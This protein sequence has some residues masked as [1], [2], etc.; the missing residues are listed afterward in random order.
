MRNFFNH[1]V[2][3]LLFVSPVLCA[4]QT[5]SSRGASDGFKESV[6]ASVIPESRLASQLEFLSDSLCAGR[7][8]GT[9][10]SAEAAFW[11]ERQYRMMRLLPLGSDYSHSFRA[12][13]I[14]GHNILGMIPSTVPSDRYIV[15]MAHYDNLG[16]LEGHF[17]PGADSNASGVVAMLSVAHIQASLSA[18]G[19]HYDANVIYVALDAKQRSMAGASALYDE[20]AKGS[21]RNPSTGALITTQ[22]VELVVNLDILGSSLAPLT[23]GREDFLMMLGGSEDARRKLTEANTSSKTFLQLSNQYYGSSDFTDLFLNRVSDQRIFIEHKVNSVMFTS[24]ITMSTN[25]I[26]DNVAS[27]NIPVFRKR[28][29]LIYNWLEKVAK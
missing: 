10:G 14:S 15:V 13:E 24:G 8:T 17:Y 6:I 19:S 23:K 29:L 21:L 3:L 9:R 18:L 5:S 20:I 25:K 2:A 1:I 28:I 16:V 26:E 12:G 27:L 4:G 11:I 7:A 22:R